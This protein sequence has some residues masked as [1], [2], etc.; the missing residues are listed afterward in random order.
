MISLFG[1]LIVIGG[2][3]S[4]LCWLLLLVRCFG[5]EYAVALLGCA[6][7]LRERAVSVMLALVGHVQQIAALIWLF[8]IQR[9]NHD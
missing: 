2:K 4:K 6:T 3:A 9:H 8:L 5:P 1:R 7:A